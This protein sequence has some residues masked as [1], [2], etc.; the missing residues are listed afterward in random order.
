MPAASTATAPT[1]SQLSAS[2]ALLLPLQP[3]AAAELELPFLYTEW[4]YYTSIMVLSALVASQKRAYGPKIFYSGD[5]HRLN[6]DGLFSMTTWVSQFQKGKT[7]LDLN[8]ATQVAEDGR[9][10]RTSI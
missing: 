10:W 2:T 1:V 4:G 7:S 6:T 3:L 9:F 8:E 5:F